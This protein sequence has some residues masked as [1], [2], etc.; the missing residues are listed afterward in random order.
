MSG[1]HL[2][3]LGTGARTTGAEVAAT[4]TPA[5]TAT[6]RAPESP[7]VATVATVAVATAAHSRISSLQAQLAEDAGRA[8]TCRSCAHFIPGDGP[9]GHCH[10][11]G[12]EA[13]P[14]ALFECSGH[15][16][17]TLAVRRQRVEQQ[18]RDAPGLRLTADVAGAALRMPERDEYGRRRAEQ[19]E[20][21]GVVSIIVAVRTQLGI[22]SG[23]LQAPRERF[24]AGLFLAYLKSIPEI[25]S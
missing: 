4:A 1:F 21:A 9:L 17:S 12:A 6:K 3:C 7:S 13:F 8:V 10:R 20:P 24:D 22:V 2:R 23:E 19:P 14:D 15:Q 25:P 18:L 11:Y 5:T 16:P